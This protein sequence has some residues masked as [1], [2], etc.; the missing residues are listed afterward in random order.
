ML[1]KMTFVRPTQ[2]PTTT[3]EA[4]KKPKAAPRAAIAT[5]SKAVQPKKPLSSF[6]IFSM[7]FVKDLRKKEPALKISECMSRAGKHW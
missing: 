4:P 3:I 2:Q 7:E 6:I 1:P 5:Y